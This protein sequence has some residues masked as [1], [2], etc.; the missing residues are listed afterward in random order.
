LIG[1]FSVSLVP[2]LEGKAIAKRDLF[3]HFP[4]YL[5]AYNRKTDQGRDPLFRT[6]PGT[7]M[8]SGKWKLH[9]YFEDGGLE[10][11][12]LTE[13]MREQNDKIDSRSDIALKMFDRMN[14]WRIRVDAPIPNTLNPD[15]EPELKTN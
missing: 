1:T 9:Q 12:D 13:D 6:R 15:Y 7:V 3:F 8:I 10:L 4:I 11:Y 14:E 2:L 5:Q